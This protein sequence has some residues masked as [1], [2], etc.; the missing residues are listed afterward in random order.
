MQGTC[1]YRRA[2]TSKDMDCCSGTSLKTRTT[3]K[4]RTEEKPMCNICTT[5]GRGRVRLQVDQNQL[6]R[7]IRQN[8]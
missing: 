4:H 8:R 5:S 7:R 2:Y 3:R 1:W 6:R